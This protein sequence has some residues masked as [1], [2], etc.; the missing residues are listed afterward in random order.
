MLHPLYL[1][2]S[3]PCIKYKVILQNLMDLGRE[4]LKQNMPNGFQDK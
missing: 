2:V 3:I 1:F 4:V